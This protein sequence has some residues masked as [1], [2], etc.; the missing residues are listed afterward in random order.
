M[1]SCKLV[2]VFINLGIANSFFS[3]KQ[4]ADQAIIKQY[5]SAISFFIWLAIY[6]EF[7]ISYSVK[8]FSWYRANLGDIHW[9]LV[10]FTKII[11]L[12]IKYKSN[13]T[14]ILVRYIYTD[15]A[16]LKDRQKS[17]GKYIFLFSR[18]FVFHQSKQ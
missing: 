5:Q 10:S 17:K 3:S 4:Q 2:S 14:D 6:I 1:A 16:E 12:G 13:A 11:E 9:N 15:Q 8:V 7:D 18:G